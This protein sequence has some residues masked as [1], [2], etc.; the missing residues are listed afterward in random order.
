MYLPGIS[1][2]AFHAAAEGGHE[3][4]IRLFLN[5]GFTFRRPLGLLMHSERRRSSGKNLLRS[6]SLD[7]RTQNNRCNIRRKK[8]E[9]SEDL[10]TFY[11]KKYRKNYALEVAASNGH[12]G[13]MELIL[14]NWAELGISTGEIGVSLQKASGNGHEEIVKCI[15]CRKFDVAPYLNGALNAAARNGHLGVV[16]TLTAHS[17]LS[18]P[19][20]DQTAKVRDVVVKQV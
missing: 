5:R 7:Y 6:S 15:L 16:D 14:D 13:I 11:R 10:S 9:S 2:D 17:Q 3:N 18:L 20:D 19:V 1:K 8:P 12:H 4:V